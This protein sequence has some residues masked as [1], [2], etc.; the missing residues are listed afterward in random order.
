M[1]T[2][3]ENGVLTTR[4]ILANTDKKYYFDNYEAEIGEPIYYAAHKSLYIEDGYGGR[5]FIGGPTNYAACTFYG[6]PALS[7]DSHGY[8]NFYFT[9]YSRPD[10]NCPFGFYSQTGQANPR[11][12]TDIEFYSPGVYRVEADF[13]FER[14]KDSAQGTPIGFA[15]VRRVA[16]DYLPDF[17]RNEIEQNREVS[18][19]SYE[20][21]G[22]INISSYIAIKPEDVENEVRYTFT[23]M[24]PDLMDLAA[25]PGYASGTGLETIF[26]GVNFKTGYGVFKIV[27][28]SNYYK[29]VSR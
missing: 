7:Q 8:Y 5:I 26:P 9:D 28:V 3:D 27:K 20:N 23:N 24:F 6:R 29:N 19:V 21:E 1:S 18:A 22:H 15:L 17:P 14:H 12:G 13:H 25:S 2:L 4:L 11:Y 10:G 16:P